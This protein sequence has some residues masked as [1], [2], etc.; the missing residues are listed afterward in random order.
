VAA[1]GRH[2]KIPSDPPL[3]WPKEAAEKVGA[4]P[5]TGKKSIKNCFCGGGEAVTTKTIFLSHLSPAVKRRGKGAKKFPK[6]GLSQLSSKAEGRGR[7]K[8]HR[9]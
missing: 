9:R 6:R 8:G 7:I 1:S 2:R 5:S 4:G 3:P